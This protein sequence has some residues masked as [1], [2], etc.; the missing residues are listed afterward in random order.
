MTVVMPDLD[1]PGHRLSGVQVLIG[2]TLYAAMRFDPHN[3]QD[4]IET[5]PM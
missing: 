4:N 3:L 5:L 2:V 1:E